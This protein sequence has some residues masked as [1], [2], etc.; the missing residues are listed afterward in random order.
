MSPSP[1]G[2]FADPAVPPPFA[3]H[4]GAGCVSAPDQPFPSAARYGQ[5]SSGR[6]RWTDSPARDQPARDPTGVTPVRA[7]VTL[8]QP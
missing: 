7:S 8:E 5:T 6:A 1:G 3:G 4:G 2:R